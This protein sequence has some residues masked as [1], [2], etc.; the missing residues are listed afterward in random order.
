MSRVWLITGTS[1][2]LGRKL[3][4]AV[5]A[6]GQRLVATARRPEMLADLAAAYGSQIVTAPLDVTDPRAAR[7][8]VRTA[9]D[10]FGVLDVVV[11]NAGF[12]SIAPVEDVTDG[13]FHSQIDTNLYGVLNVTRAALPILRAQRSGHIIQIASIGGRVGAPGFG[14]HQATKWAV[15]GLSEALANEVAPLGIAVTIIEPGGLR[16]DYNGSSRS[17]GS[18]RPEYEPTA[19]A[20]A[21]A[22]G[23]A[24][25]REPGDPTKAARA[26]LKVAA[27][28]RPPLRLLLGSDAVEYAAT[29][30]QARADEDALWRELSLSTDADDT[31]TDAPWLGWSTQGPTISEF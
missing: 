24:S 10:H 3:A 22:L 23:Q 11:N 1:R 7:T 8:A 4:E 28:A 14:V 17:V 31:R 27:A 29:A 20:I 12:G 9:M 2:G 19:G 21:A 13:D 6:D 5:L 18:I 26:I 25:G 15:E 16:T 30:A